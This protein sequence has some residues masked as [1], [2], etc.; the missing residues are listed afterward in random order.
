MLLLKKYDE[1]SNEKKSWKNSLLTTWEWIAVEKSTLT[2]FNFYWQKFEISQKSSSF[3]STWNHNFSFLLFAYFLFF[4]ALRLNEKP[5]AGSSDESEVLPKYIPLE[6]SVLKGTQR[7]IADLALFQSRRFRTNWSL[8]PTACS[9]TT[10][11]L[12]LKETDLSR[13]ITV[14]LSTGCLKRKFCTPSFFKKNKWE[15][16]RRPQKTA[17]KIYFSC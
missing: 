9:F 6:D 11:A 5:I 3:S 2:Y 4:K 13:V 8:N 1:E 12:N 14:W 16:G 10:L 17:K 7:C 15:K